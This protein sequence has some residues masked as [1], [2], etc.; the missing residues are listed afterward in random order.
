MKKIVYFTLSVLGIAPASP[1]GNTPT[2]KLSMPSTYF[3]KNV[4]RPFTAGS[5]PQ[6]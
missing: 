2:P 3:G 6:G 4:Q 1:N 5:K